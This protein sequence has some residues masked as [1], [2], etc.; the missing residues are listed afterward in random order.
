MTSAIPIGK[1]DIWCWLMT[2]LV[3]VFHATR[4]RTLVLRVPPTASLVPL[5]EP[6]VT[7]VRARVVAKTVFAQSF[8]L[9]SDD[10]THFCAII[11]T[12]FRRA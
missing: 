6:W 7:R 9:V 11:I 1:L 3:D 2:V 10:Q 5:T 4:A 12:D 8:D